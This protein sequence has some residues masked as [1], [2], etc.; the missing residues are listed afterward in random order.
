MASLQWGTVSFNGSYIIGKATIT[1]R[2]LH[3]TLKSYLI[4]LVCTVHAGRHTG[5]LSLCWLGS[6]FR[7]TARCWP[8]VRP[9][10]TG[11]CVPPGCRLRC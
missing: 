10:S 4:M 8:H 5:M 7:C 2:S 3:E 11:C 9:T 1:S 6:A